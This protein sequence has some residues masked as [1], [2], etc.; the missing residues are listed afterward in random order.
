MEDIWHSRR[1]AKVWQSAV[2]TSPTLQRK[3]FLRPAKPPVRPTELV[4]DDEDGEAILYQEI[5]YDQPLRFNPF[6]KVRHCGFDGQGRA[7]VRVKN[8]H[9]HRPIGTDAAM[10]DSMLLTQPPITELGI[11]RWTSRPPHAN[12]VRQSGITL[13]DVADHFAD[14]GDINERF[15]ERPAWEYTYMVATTEVLDLEWKRPE[16]KEGASPPHLGLKASIYTSIAL[17]TC[18]LMLLIGDS[19]TQWYAGRWPEKMLRGG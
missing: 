16:E 13:G 5:F 3:L 17:S 15:G 11:S 9:R 2:H 19:W 14:H 12:L 1:V 7:Y 6:L 10:F 18:A 4:E 8:P